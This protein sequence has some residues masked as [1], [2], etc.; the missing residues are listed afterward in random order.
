MAT[1]V[2]WLQ[3]E[4]SV[5]RLSSQTYDIPVIDTAIKKIPHV[6][7]V[8]Y[9]HPGN[10][11]IF[12]GLLVSSGVSRWVSE[13]EQEAIAGTLHVHHVELLH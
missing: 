9:H 11:R 13:Q 4:L 2:A 12:E 5:F 6:S 3:R 7:Q 8:R 10:L 1:D